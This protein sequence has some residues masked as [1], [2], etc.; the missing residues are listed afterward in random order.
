MPGTLDYQENGEWPSHITEIRKTRYPIEAYTKGL[1]AKETQ[2]FGGSA[3][4]RYV[5]VGFIARRTKDGKHSELHFRIYQPSGQIYKTDALRKILDF[6]DEYGLGLLEVMGQTGGLIISMDPEKADEAIDVLRSLGTDVGDTGD[7]FRDFASCVGPALCEYAQYD[8]LAARDHYMTYE[9]IYN[10][11][12]NQMFPFKV[13]LKFSGCPMDCSRAVHRADFGFIGMWK[14]APDVDENLLKG[15]IKKE[16]IKIQNLVQGCPS[17]AITQDGNSDGIRIDPEKCQ[18]SMNCIRYAFPAIKPG[19]EKKIALLAGGNIKGRFG[20]KMAKPVTI[21][22][23]YKDAE[24]FIMK[25]INIWE[26]DA[27]HKDRIGDTLVKL[28]FSKTIDSVKDTL[29]VE[30]EGSPSGQKRIINS[31]V[32][33]DAERE[34]YSVWAK[35]IMNEYG[36]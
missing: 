16:G 21:L 28:G 36:E 19:K 34:R 12:S 5:Y 14:G 7:T 26:D 4:I 20:P 31:A 6:S 11:L 27:P 22:D 9:P 18:K 13:K 15:K 2:W 10:N 8:T 24:D 32:L 23:D 17:G 33:T 3:K 35:K 29:P 30:P 1:D 25:I